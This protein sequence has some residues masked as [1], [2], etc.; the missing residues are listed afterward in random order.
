MRCLLFTVSLTLLAS[1]PVLAASVASPRDI[2]EKLYAPYLA[3]PH[4]EESDTPS[5]L[6]AIRPKASKALRHAIHRNDVC[7]RQEEGVCH[8]DFDIIIDAQ[9][10]DISHFSAA[11]G[12]DQST[13]LPIVTARFT[14]GYPR[15]VR[16]YFISE[17]GAWKIDEIEAS[18]HDKRGK[19]RGYYALKTELS[20]PF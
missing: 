8:I 7:E 19:V 20:K 4:A 15:E 9:D 17:E 13:G 11:D 2:V 3:D 10:W 14:N 5:A 18:Q 1:S 16:Y 12:E 6:D